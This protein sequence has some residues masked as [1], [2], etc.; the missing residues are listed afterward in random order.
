MKNKPSPATKAAL[1]LAPIEFPNSKSRPSLG[2]TANKV[3]L[4]S[5]LVPSKNMNS[6]TNAAQMI[7]GSNVNSS[8]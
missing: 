6:M 5:A 4:T 7:I 3:T 1:E 8:S 2:P